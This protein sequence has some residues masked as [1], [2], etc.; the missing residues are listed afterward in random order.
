MDAPTITSERFA[1]RFKNWLLVD[2]SYD[3]AEDLLVDNRVL[4]DKL[5]GELIEHER[6]TQGTWLGS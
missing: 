1:S 4:L 3:R 2:E 6:W 5:A